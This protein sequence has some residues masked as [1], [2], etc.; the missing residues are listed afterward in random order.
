[1]PGG[2]DPLT[3]L[4]HNDWVTRISP[5][6]SLDPIFVVEPD[7]GGGSG[8]STSVDDIWDYTSPEGW[9][10][11]NAPGCYL[12]MQQVIWGV[13]G[14]PAVPFS[15]TVQQAWRP[16]PAADA[17]I[18]IATQVQ[19]TIGEAGDEGIAYAVGETSLSAIMIVTSNIEGPIA[20]VPQVLQLSPD[21][22]EVR[23]Q[24]T[25]VRINGSV[26]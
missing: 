5:Y 15:G 25:I 9:I 2:S 12:L 18:T 22:Q 8:E 14:P 3:L 17:G 19:T 6:F 7:M 11:T 24:Q 16:E 1:M 4:T 21:P 26:D 10:T 13:I 23:V 20:F